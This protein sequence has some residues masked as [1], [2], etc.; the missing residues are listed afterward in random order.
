MKTEIR[1]SNESAFKIKLLHVLEL[2]SKP[3]RLIFHVVALILWFIVQRLLNVWNKG[4]EI[5][6]QNR[7]H[8]S[9]VFLKLVAL[10][11]VVVLVIFLVQYFYNHVF[12]KSLI[13]WMIGI[14]GGST[15]VFLILYLYHLF[16]GR[17]G[18]IQL[19]I[20][21]TDYYV[22]H[23]LASIIKI[24]GPPR[25]GKDTTGISITSILV[26][27]FNL[28]IRMLMHKIKKIC[29]IFDFNLVDNVCKIHYTYFLSSSRN[30]RRDNFINI[31]SRDR[32]KCFLKDRYLRE[33]D[34]IEFLQEYIDSLKN[35]VDFKAKYMFNDGISNLHFLDLLNEYMFLYV[36]LYVI[37]NF[38]IINQPYI[39]NPETGL[40]G[41]ELS[42]FY[43]ALASKPN[44]K[45]TV[46]L[47]DGQQC[48]I[49]Y[50]EKIEFPLLDWTIWYETE[51]DTWLPN[52]DDA[53]EQLLNDYR[54]RDFK[55][56]Y[57]H[58]FK[59]FKMIQIC[60]NAGRMNIKLRELDACYIHILDRVEIP[61]AS[62]RNAILSIIQK[63]IDKLA[64]R[65]ADKLDNI[66]NSSLNR[67]QQKINYYERLYRSTMNDKYLVKLE[68][69]ES[70]SL[71][72]SSRL[73]DFF[74]KLNKCLMEKI[75]QNRRKY[76]V[77]KV[78]AI[79]SD[80]PD[81]PNVQ[82]VTLKDLNNR[83]KPL[84]HESFLVDLYFRMTDSMG[85]YNDRFMEGLAEE[86]AVQSVLDFYHVINWDK[87]MQIT[88]DILVR[89][90]YPAGRNFMKV[91][92]EEFFNIRYVPIEN[93]KQ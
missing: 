14:V 51:L 69:L 26:R 18:L 1:L 43:L 77:I 28:C 12:I 4:Y 38:V 53:V 70:K 36:R 5:L 75:E 9:K 71:K 27:F 31:C 50:K 47:P 73:Q 8:L 85:R 56:F 15:G 86:Q 11:E 33:L 49:E 2:V 92:E 52:R 63:V 61:G 13:L 90:G 78:T 23:H 91:S 34:Y 89:M 57:G 62:K 32:F 40:M 35:R 44:V 80:Q 82:R 42:I 93:K 87:R 54:I 68:Q 66:N 81:T 29:Y 83:N 24:F 39:E 79:I 17:D 21:Q 6:Y 59:S 58:F 46:Q 60:H 30:I 25:V 65:G 41:K 3:P 7:K 37:K 76:G 22:C 48:T 16:I 10:V 88:R 55:A 74:S 19:Y 64:T 72:Q 45:K 67:Q 20:L 84:Y